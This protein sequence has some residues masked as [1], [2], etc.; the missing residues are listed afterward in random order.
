MDLTV[1]GQNW[2]YR[3][4]FLLSQRIERELIATQIEHNDYKKLSDDY[5]DQLADINNKLI[6]TQLA[7]KECSDLL[8]KSRKAMSEYNHNPKT[9]TRF[10]LT[11]IDECLSNP[12][13]IAA[14]KCK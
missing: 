5:F 12:I 6:A 13:T 2:G 8:D 1:Q 9:T 14:M 10:Y 7:L 4:M 3:D 11:S